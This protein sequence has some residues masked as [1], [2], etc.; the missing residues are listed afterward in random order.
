MIAGAIVCRD[1]VLRFCIPRFFG[2]V[3]VNADAR[4]VI[5]PY[6]R[7]FF[8]IADMNP[9][10]TSFANTDGYLRVGVNWARKNIDGDKI[11]L[12][13]RVQRIDFKDISGAA[14]RAKMY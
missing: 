7:P 3:C 2:A 10:L 11:V 12:E 4:R 5:A 1:E 13:A 14:V 6:A 9:K 8:M